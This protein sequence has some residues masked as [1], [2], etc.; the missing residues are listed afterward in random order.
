MHISDTKFWQKWV[1]PTSEFHQK[2]M[3]K[4]WL[5]PQNGRA[6]ILITVFAVI[7][8]VVANYS[9]R[10]HQL[11][12]WQ[13]NPGYFYLGDMPL[14]STT[15][16]SYYLAQAR[17]LE[18]GE[19]NASYHAKRQYPNIA[20]R[21]QA[22]QPENLRD[23]PLL[24]VI[25]SWLSPSADRADILNAAHAMLPITAAIT[26]LAII[27]ALGITGY[28]LEA[29]VAAVGGGLSAAY[30][31]RS[32]AGRIDTDQ[33]NL[34]FFYLLMGLIILAARSK[35]LRVAVVLTALGALVGQLFLWWYSE[36]SEFLIAALI[37]LLWV[38]IVAHLNWR[39]TAFLGVVFLLLS[40]MS[41]QISGGAYVVDV[42]SYDALIFPNTFETITELRVVPLNQIL[43]SATGSAFLGV[44]CLIGLGL[45]AIRHPVLAIA[46]G[47]LA[48]FGL[49]NFII[50]NRAIFYS[51]PILWFGGAWFATTIAR[52]AYSVSPF[53]DRFPKQISYLTV[54]TIISVAFGALAWFSSPTNYVPRPSFPT[55]M[56]AAFQ[57]L[58]D[59]VDAKGGV[60][61]SWWDYGY[62]SILLNELPVLHDPGSQ[63]LPTTHLI[64]RALLETDQRETAAMLR[65]LTRDGRAGLSRDGASKAA[66]YD[67]VRERSELPTKDIYLVLT[68]QMGQW[69][70]SISK[71]GN[72]DIDAGR[73][74]RLRGNPNGSVVGYQDLN[75]SNLSSGSFIECNGNQ[76]D[77]KMGTI[78]G[79][80]GLGGV[81]IIRD[82][83]LDGATRFNNRQNRFLQLHYTGNKGRAFLIHDS[84]YDSSFNQLFH[85]GQSYEGGFKLIYDHYPHARIYKLD[86]QSR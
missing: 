69:M 43:T 2:I 71:L 61:V 72:W 16:A 68:E 60:V 58:E 48:A 64:A 7:M 28:W 75:C 33:L 83:K 51:A 22:D 46:Y 57:S 77:L 70:G 52:A 47:P 84:L 9:V 82:G 17:A 18:Q 27:F 29:S 50:G 38:D 11:S 81:A 30:L 10:Q 5:R 66:L 53:S 25:V 86:G 76:F 74:T 1:L 14:F 19:S 12:V 36:K 20:N 63:T 56:M 40:G 26:A 21:T 13:E 15:D 35:N 59:R 65:Y 32:S 8:A 39:R 3:D 54:T 62:A 4:D 44:F 80:P 42:L 24:S 23:V 6:Y 31:V 49:L 45:W 34:G 85:R 73:P 37:A 55:Q 41:F 67:A 79:N 78:N